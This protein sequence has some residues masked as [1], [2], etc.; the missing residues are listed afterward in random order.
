MLS[1]LGTVRLPDGTT[2]GA[3][4]VLGIEWMPSSDVTDRRF[5]FTIP[6][7]VS[8]PRT[9]RHMLAQEIAILAAHPRVR[10]VAGSSRMLNARHDE[11]IA[12]GGRGIRVC[13]C[14]GMWQCA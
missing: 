9:A 13:S 12:S 11:L 6:R 7:E 5:S 3:P 2:F 8:L 4:N 10:F 1:W 14:C